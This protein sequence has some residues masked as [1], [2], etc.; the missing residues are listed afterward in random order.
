MVTILIFILKYKSV[1]NIKGQKW[2][3]ILY[4]DMNDQSN[5]KEILSPYSKDGRFNSENECMDFTG[6]VLDD[7]ELGTV[8]DYECV[9]LD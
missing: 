4:Y 6:E 2:Y 9:G 3:G 1:K 7:M 8:G 5:Y